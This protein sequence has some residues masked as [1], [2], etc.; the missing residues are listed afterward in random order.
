MP[1]DDFADRQAADYLLSKGFALAGSSYASNGWAVKEALPDQI[2]VLNEFRK[3]F[4]KPK[5]TIA[6]GQSMGGLITADLVQ[7]YPQYFSG[8]LPMCGILG[9]GLGLWNQNLDLEFA[10]KALMQQDPNPAVSVPASTLQLAN[11]TAWPANVGAATAALT[12]AQQTAQGRA[13]LALASALFNLPT[14]SDPTA[15]EPGPTDYEAQEQNQYNELQ[16]QLLFV[17]GFRQELE[18]RAGGNPTW[19]TGVD[20]RDLFAR[21]ADRSEVESLYKAAGLDLGRDLALINAAPRVTANPAAARYLAQNV[22]FNG[23]IA[24]P[25]LSLHTTSDWLVVPPHEQSY[26][27]AVKRAGNSGLLRQLWVHRAGHCTFTDG[28]MLTALKV[29]IKRLDSGHWEKSYSPAQLNAQAASYGQS[30]NQISP[31]L[32]AP[33]NYPVQPG[34]ALFTPPV[35]LRP[36][37]LPPGGTSTLP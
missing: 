29:L 7:T 6:W 3:D 13:R 16:T 11:V 28:E 21:S 20:Y 14:W 34:F 15:A 22:A 35:F 17:F 2:G 37:V 27:A 31:S 25:V 23:K 19:N 9:G 12:G 5:R 32:G 24:I 30:F 33:A 18:S 10:F 26:A 8:A 1:A 36:F 4:G